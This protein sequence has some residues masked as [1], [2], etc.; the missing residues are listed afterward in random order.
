VPLARAAHE[1][2]RTPGTELDGSETGGG[3]RGVRGRLVE[4]RHRRRQPRVETEPPAKDL[5]PADA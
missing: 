5:E 3:R 2:A 1:A 4:L